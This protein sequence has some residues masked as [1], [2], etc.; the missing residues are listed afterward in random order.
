M[1]YGLMFYWFGWLFWGITTFFMKK[2]RLRTLFSAL[3]LMMLICSNVEFLFGE[4]VIFF[5]ILFLLVTSLL[6][7]ATLSKPL[8]YFLCSFILMIGYTAISFWKHHLSIDILVQDIFLVP[9]ICWIIISL[10]VKGLYHR[11]IISMLGITAGE[12]LHGLVLTSYHLPETIGSHDFFVVLYMVLLYLLVVHIFRKVK[13]GIYTSIN[14]YFK[15]S[16]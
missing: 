12:I 14:D 4:L 8:Y 1:T 13:V 5:P 11:L 3:I 15:P 16:S 10:L 2:G 7:Y 6:L 9:L